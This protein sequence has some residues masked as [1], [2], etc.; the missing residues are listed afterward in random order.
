MVLWQSEITRRIT[1][2]KWMCSFL[3][4]WET[5]CKRSKYL[6]SLPI[7]RLRYGQKHKH[8]TAPVKTEVPV[9]IMFSSI[10]SAV[11]W[12]QELFCLSLLLLNELFSHFD[13]L[14]P[15]S[16]WKQTPEEEALQSRSCTGCQM[17]C[18]SE[19]GSHLF[20]VGLMV[21]VWLMWYYA[22]FWTNPFL[23]SPAAYSR[24]LWTPQQHEHIQGSLK[25]PRALESSSPTK[26]LLDQCSTTICTQP[27]GNRHSPECHPYCGHHHGISGVYNRDSQDHNASQE[28]Q[29][30]SNCCSVSVWHNALDSIYTGQTLPA[31][32]YSPWPSSSAAAAQ[33]ETSQ[34]SSIWHW[35]VTWIS[36]NQGWVCAHCSGQSSC[37]TD[38]AAG[39]TNVSSP[40]ETGQSSKV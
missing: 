9:C 26:H 25:E 28:T 17:H 11:P 19:W 3:F 20:V 6:P 23:T 36:G 33:G 40:Q 4:S 14:C 8:F 24:D 38:S 35:T 18:W 37:M 15:H 34:M 1:E 39:L 21:S 12:G 32:P 7:E 5:A 31:G 16:L 29:R 27:A 22:H 13:Q 10:H 30:H 2:K